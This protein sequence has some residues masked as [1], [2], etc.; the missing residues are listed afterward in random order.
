MSF[1]NRQFFVGMLAGAFLL[2][3]IGIVGIVLLGIA[4]QR[5]ADGPGSIPVIGGLNPP[6]VPTDSDSEMGWRMRDLNGNAVDLAELS[7]S[8]V[9]VNRWATWC[10]PC[11][12]EMPSI[13]KLAAG[14]ADEDIAFVIVSNEPAETV[15]PF[16][17]DKGWNLPIY[18]ARQVP[19][20][21]Q[22]RGIPATFVLDDT[23]RIVFAHVGSA[24][25]DAPA[26][27]E[28]FDRLLRSSS[29]SAN[30]SPD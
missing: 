15:A 13:E 26:S 14:L 30:S 24:L 7:H 16:V 1:F 12:K 22:S 8:V 27:L 10:A 21:F 9:F 29:A 5:A 6:P 20:V 17:A 4:I 18:L 3:A 19:P 23:R 25:W 11:L 2:V 28:Y